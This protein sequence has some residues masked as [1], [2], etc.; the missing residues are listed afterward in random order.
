VRFSLKE[1]ERG[2]D[3]KFKALPKF[4]NNLSFRGVHFNKAANKKNGNTP[5]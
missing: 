5:V 3:L 1:K 2:K 4:S